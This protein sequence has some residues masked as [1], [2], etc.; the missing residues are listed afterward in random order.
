MMVADARYCFRVP[1]TFADAKAAP[2]LCAGLIGYRSLRKAVCGGIHLSDI[3]AFQYEL[4]WREREIVSVA[5]LT[6]RDGEEFLALAPKV[7]I[8]T[9]IEMFPLEAANEALI[10]LRAGTLRGA[11]VLLTGS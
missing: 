1:S 2:L 8:R 7:P 10:R 6:R 11:A 9:E 4:L 3:P 5:N